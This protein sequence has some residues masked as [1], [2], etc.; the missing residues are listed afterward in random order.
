[1]S[2]QLLLH[3]AERSDAQSVPC[4]TIQHCDSPEENTVTL[5]L[6]IPIFVMIILNSMSWSTNDFYFTPH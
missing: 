4:N 5:A 2:A 3:S 1:M 6:G